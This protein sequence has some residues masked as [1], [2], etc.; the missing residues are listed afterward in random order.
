MNRR[1]FLATAT[2]LSLSGRAFAAIASLDASASRTPDRS[3]VRIDWSDKARPV[4]IFQS[5]DPD[6]GAGTARAIKAATAGTAEVEAAISPRPYFRLTTR[7]GGQTRV[8]ERLLP[9]EGGRNFRDL[10][11]YRS[12]DGRQVRWGRIYRSGVMSGLT[13]GDLEYLGQLGVAVVCDLRNPRERASEPSP[14]LARHGAQVAAFDYD[15]DSSLDAFQGLQ[16]RDQAVTA[17]ATSYVRFIDV[18][19]PNLADMFGRLV[20]AKAPLAMN[21]SAGKDRTGMA[22]ALVLSVLGVPRQ[23]IVADYALTQVYTPPAMYVSQLAQT[24]KLPGLSDRQTQMM[25]QMPPDV[26]AV[27]MS[28]DPEVMR[29]ALAMIDRQYGGPVQLAKA[30]FGLTDAKVASLRHTYLI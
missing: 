10:G 6:G 15:M 13:A 19:T 25:K 26:L 16:A 18:L 2:A 30:R 14:F 23:A 20:E 11:G 9:L 29:Q 22:S 24:G 8:A 28:S 5:S 12:A 4:T 17:F 7:D 21:C 27:M 3:H 1:S